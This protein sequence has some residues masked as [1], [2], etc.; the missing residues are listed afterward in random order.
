MLRT[1][2]LRHEPDPEGPPPHFDWLLEIGIGTPDDARVVPTFRLGRRPDRLEIGETTPL[3]RIEDH[4]GIWLGRVEQ[5]TFE[6]P[7]PLGKATPIRIGVI[8]HSARTDDSVMESTIRW[9]QSTDAMTYRIEP[10]SGSRLHLTRLAMPDLD[11]TA[12][13]EPAG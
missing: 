10:T 11:A 7:P 5:R 2:I 12:T 3:D 1:S 6:L 4:R 8:R 13:G 9:S